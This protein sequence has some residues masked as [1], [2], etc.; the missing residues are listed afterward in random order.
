[1]SIS[2]AAIDST[3]THLDSA[4]TVS[5][6]LSRIKAEAKNTIGNSLVAEL[7]GA[8]VHLPAGSGHPQ[9]KIASNG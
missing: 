4:A 2:V 1:M 9:L 6:R 5:S 8:I 3:S 7:S